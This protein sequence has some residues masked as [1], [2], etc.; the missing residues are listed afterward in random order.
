MV[1]PQPIYQEEEM[2]ENI[3]TSEAIWNYSNIKSKDHT[4]NYGGE[5]DVAQS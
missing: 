4:V 1:D 3:R 2:L 5:E